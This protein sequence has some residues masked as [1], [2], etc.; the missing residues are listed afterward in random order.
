M[1]NTILVFK[2]YLN[3]ILRSKYTRYI[4]RLVNLVLFVLVSALVYKNRSQ[5]SLFTDLI[6]IR[7]ILLCFLA[8]A[9]SYTLQFAI[10]AGLMGYPAGMKIDALRDYVNSTLM[11]R[12]PG[13]MWKL[14]GRLTI[15]KTSAVSSRTVL[16][17]NLTEMLII[18]LGNAILLI[19]LWSGQALA[20]IGLAVIAAAIL[21]AA[22]RINQPYLMQGRSRIWS[23]LVW[24][25]CAMGAWLAGG[26]FIYL[27]VNPFFVL[28]KASI[29]LLTVIV[30][31]CRV[32]AA[33]LVLQIVPLGSFLRDAT[34]VVFLQTS[35]PLSHAL[36]AATVV[37]LA[38][39]VSDIGI[40]WLFL[41]FASRY[42]KPAPAPGGQG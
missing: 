36:I 10:W 17:V 33:G 2:G 9:L 23:W 15:H 12:L 16:L 42:K 32:G 6:D 1:S 34:L 37:R 5:I 8:Y 31:W 20:Q 41:L 35:I 19:I 25:A 11:G 21:G 26:I 38:L 7:N 14:L 40:G 18:G 28:A 29:N 24:L 13:N 22:I 4:N 27:L 30:I 39:L 3:T